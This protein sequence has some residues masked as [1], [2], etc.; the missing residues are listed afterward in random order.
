MFRYF[1]FRCMS[2]VLGLTFIYA[3][4]LTPFEISINNVLFILGGSFFILYGI[5]PSLVL[6]IFKLDPDEDVTE[7]TK[8][9]FKIIFNFWRT[10]K[11]R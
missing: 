3:I 9:D 2:F 4:F 7:E 11:D 10:K 5:R 6:K 1:L 8:K